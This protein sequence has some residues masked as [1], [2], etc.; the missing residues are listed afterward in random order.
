MCEH[1][2]LFCVTL[3]QNRTQWLALVNAVMKL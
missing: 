2:E 3:D 1:V